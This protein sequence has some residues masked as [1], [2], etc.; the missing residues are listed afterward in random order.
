MKKLIFISFLVFFSSKSYCQWQILNWSGMN[1]YRITDLYFQNDS[2]GFASGYYDDGSPSVIFK[3]MDG[4]S[5]WTSDTIPTAIKDI[6]FISVDTGYAVGVA[7]KV[8]RTIDQGNSWQLLNTLSPFW[9]LRC[10]AFRTHHEAYIGGSNDFCMPCFG[11]NVLIKTTDGWVTY[12]SVPYPITGFI[13][14]DLPANNYCIYFK[15]S[16]H[17]YVGGGAYLL[18]T[19]NGGNSWYFEDGMTQYAVFYDIASF[20]SVLYGVGGGGH[21]NQGGDIELSNDL[22]NT[23]HQTPYDTL[24]GVDTTFSINSVAFVTNNI[25]YSVGC[26]QNGGVGGLPNVLITEDG[27][28][29][30]EE[31]DFPEDQLHNHPY[32]LS[33]VCP[34]PQTCYCAGEKVIMKKENADLGTSIKSI[35]ADHNSQLVVYP[36]PVTVTAT[37]Q[38]Q[39][40][41]SGKSTVTVQNCL[42]QTLQT[43]QLTNNQK[44]AIVMS[45]YASG[46]YFIKCFDGKQQVVMKVVKE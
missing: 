3:T 43:L 39:T 21:A 25:G 37:I 31:D 20:D 46:M 36:N 13:P 32:L 38:Y 4:G 24:F 41:N 35:S 10:I 15:D 26:G 28:Y 17:G 40:T 11:S 44:Q 29:T 9:D 2:V 45:T 8:Y 23:W 1:T 6:E 18:R 27:G 34:T 42:G 19:D 16:L 5:S 30:W 22:G 14:T 12:D 33:V 7:G